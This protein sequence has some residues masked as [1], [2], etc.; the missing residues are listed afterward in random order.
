MTKADFEKLAIERLEEAKILLDAK[1]YSGAYYLAGYG[2]ECALK[3]CIAKTTKRNSYPDKDFAIRCYTHKLGS[4]LEL[5]GIQDAVTD[6]STIR[7]LWAIVKDW[8]EQ[9]RY[10]RTVQK[11]ARELYEAIAGDNG[12][13]SWIRKHW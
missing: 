10:S 13:L 1:K 11:K 4:L 12:I 5:A 7:L 2:V 6:D 3:A 8:N 9:S